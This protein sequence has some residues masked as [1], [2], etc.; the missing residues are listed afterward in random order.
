MKVTLITW[1]GI[2]AILFLVAALS[3]CTTLNH[4]ANRQANVPDSR[5]PSAGS[6]DLASDELAEV[7]RQI[8]RLAGLVANAGASIQEFRASQ[9]QTVSTGQECLER[10]NGLAGSSAIRACTADCGRKQRIAVASAQTGIAS[11]QG[12]CQ[13][14]LQTIGALNEIRVNL[15]HNCP[16]RFDARDIPPAAACN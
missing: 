5:P 13:S 7:N 16:I 15:A 11:T 3:A 1:G 10:C 6:C 2:A 9:D 8:A 4:S 14:L 12:N